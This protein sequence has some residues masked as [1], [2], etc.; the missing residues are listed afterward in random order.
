MFPL[1]ILYIQSPIAMSIDAKVVQMMV[2][3]Y[4]ALNDGWTVRKLDTDKYE[5]KKP[6]ENITEEVT[7]EDFTTNFLKQFSSIDNFFRYLHSA[8]S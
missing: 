8:R 2:F 4:R 6:I 7:S 1:Q 5:F 3:I